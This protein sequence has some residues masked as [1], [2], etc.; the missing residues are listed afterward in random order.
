MREWAF[1]NRFLTLV[2]D[3]DE[4]SASYPGCFDKEYQL[5]ERR[6]GEIHQRPVCHE[7]LFMPLPGIKH[8]FP[9]IQPSHYT[10]QSLGCTPRQ[11]A[12]QIASSVY[13]LLLWYDIY[14][15]NCNWVDTRWQQYS[16]H[17]HTNNTQN[18]ENGTYIIIK[19]LWMKNKHQ[20][21]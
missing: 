14:V 6:M 21:L 5:L 13:S 3:R 8:W 10:T 1:I 4:W 2:L 7:E 19:K 20:V 9:V 15:F 11:M 18:T 12:E 16:T 17:L